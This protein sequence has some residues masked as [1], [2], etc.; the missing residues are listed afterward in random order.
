[1]VQD[2]I[3]KFI[4]GL[5]G[6]DYVSNAYKGGMECV[7]DNQLD[8]ALEYF[9]KDLKENPKNG[10][11]YLRIAD[12][13]ERNEDYEGAIHATNMAVKYLPK[14][15]KS[16]LMSAY[17]TMGKAFLHLAQPQKALQAY[18]EAININ[19]QDE[20][21][22]E[23]RAN[24]YIRMGN[25]RLA[26]ADYRKIKRYEPIN[27]IVTAS[28]LNLIDREQISFIGNLGNYATSYLIKKIQ[29]V[30]SPGNVDW[31]FLLGILYKQARQ[32]QKAIETFNRIVEKQQI[33]TVY[34]IL[35]MCQ[36]EEAF[37]EGALQS[38]DKALRLDSTDVDIMSYKA[39]IYYCMG[40]LVAAVSEMDMV[41]AMH[42]NY[43]QGYFKRSYFKSQVGDLNGAGEDLD[44]GLKLDSK[45]DYFYS[46]ALIEKV[47]CYTGQDKS[48]EDDKTKLEPESNSDKYRSFFYAYQEEILMSE[49]YEEWKLMESIDK[50]RMLDGLPF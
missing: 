8:E 42:P 12:I 24:I 34:Y 23:D 50:D 26:D 7:E 33:S 16:E 22:Y 41:L 1:M 38:I 5:L 2:E 32:Y 40:N 21:L 11:S 46:Y 10:Y 9:K 48:G 18:T 36:C 6:L 43:A 47:Y 45:H 31:Q 15:D 19:P 14:G 17:T 44:M 49:I 28:S 37:Y 27:D 25:Y 30:K 4:Y 3:I 35:A 13:Y 39:L 29:V 20:N